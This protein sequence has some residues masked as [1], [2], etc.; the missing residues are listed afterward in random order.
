MSSLNLA[1]RSLST[2]SVLRLVS[3][4]FRRFSCIRLGTPLLSSTDTARRTFDR[5]TV[6]EYD[7]RTFSTTHHVAQ[8]SEKGS[9]ISRKL[10]DPE[11]A[12]GTPQRFRE[13]GVSLSAIG[14][15]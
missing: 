1:A 3:P 14:F 15:V 7:V 5:P 8:S 10:T 9:R 2:P 13:F 12:E 4:G 6:Q 11:R